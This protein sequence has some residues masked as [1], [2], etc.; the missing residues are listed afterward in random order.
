MEAKL[1]IC[2]LTNDKGQP[3]YTTKRRTPFIG[4]LCT[5]ES[6][7]NVYDTLVG[8]TEAPL[9]YLLTYKLSQDHIELFFG[10]VRSC[11]AAIIIQRYDSLMLHIRDC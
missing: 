4:L 6:T 1:Y 10:A 2:K 5:I 9:K 11:G 7:I 3:M 8:C